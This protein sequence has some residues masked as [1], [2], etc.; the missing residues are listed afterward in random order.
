M[1]DKNETLYRITVEDI[2]IVAEGEGL[3]LTDEIADKV[4]YKI[5][6]MDSSGE[7]ECIEEWIRE[8]I[9]EVAK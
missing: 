3:E 8:A 6:A 4:A 7:Y 5:E 1:R 2:Y 9:E